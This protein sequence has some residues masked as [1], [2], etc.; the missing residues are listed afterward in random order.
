[1]FTMARIELRIA[2]P[3]NQT[4]TAM[5]GDD[6][7]R[8]CQACQKNVY[9]VGQMSD[10]EVEELIRRTEGKFC[11]RL[12]RRTDMRVLTSDCPKGVAAVRRRIG[13]SLAA[14]AGALAF[15]FQPV[16]GQAKVSRRPEPRTV[17]PPPVEEHVEMGDAV[18]IPKPTKSPFMGFVSSRTVKDN[19]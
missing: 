14:V 9:N 8:F 12:Y 11:A 19:K 6:K 7:V 1:M 16:M 5:T 10:A 3:C 13:A 2:K 18:A 15:V 17:V 4:W